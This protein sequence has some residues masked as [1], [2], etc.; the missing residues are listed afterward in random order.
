METQTTLETDISAVFGNQKKKA[1]ELKKTTSQDRISR[2]GIFRKAIDNN[3]GNITKALYDDYKKPVEEAILEVGWIIDEID[4]VITH[5]E[6][7]MKAQV[8]STPESLGGDAVVSRIVLEPK[9]VCLFLTPWN[10]PFLLTFR[11]LVSCLA[12]G[13]T[14]IIKPSELTPHSSQLIREIVESVFTEDEVLVVEGGAEVASELL[15]LPFDHIFYTGGTRVGKIVMKAAASHMASITM[16]LGGKCPSIIDDSADFADAAGK[17][18]WTKFLNCG[19]TCITTDYI[20]VSENRKDEFV[21]QLKST[22]TNMYGADGPGIESP[23]YAR[24]VNSN[25]YRR[26]KNLLEDALLNGAKLVTGGKT[27]DS[28]NYLSPTLLDHVTPDMAIMKEEIFGPL[29]PVLTYRTL[30]DAIDFVNGRDRPL[31]VYVYSKDRDVAEMVINNTTAGASVINHTL[32]HYVSPYLPFGGVGTSGIG[33][34]NG[35]FGF[36]DFSNQRPVLEMP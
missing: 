11:P 16:E 1:L 36:F 12:A 7:W 23:K 30:E 19:Q 15:E 6:S 14:A 10:Y 4:F 3:S 32:M 20:L 18:V 27:D 26:V 35:Y 2:L 24:M 33:R 25:H 5:L 29:L 28:E 8:V 21:A 17:I 31:G 22:I 34:G 9:G 13:N